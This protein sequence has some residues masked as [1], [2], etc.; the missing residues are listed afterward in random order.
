[1]SMNILAD[2]TTMYI[3]YHQV[4]GKLNIGYVDGFLIWVNRTG[5][6]WYKE[7]CHEGSRHIPVLPPSGFI[8]Q[9][10]ETWCYL[11]LTLQVQYH[12]IIITE[13]ISNIG[14]EYKFNHLDTDDHDL[15]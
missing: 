2:V 7:K 3:I 14:C 9:S 8:N 5:N 11:H 6:N 4:W 13:I 10:N 12:N 1:M 15:Y